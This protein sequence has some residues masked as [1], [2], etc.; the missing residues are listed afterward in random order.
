MVHLFSAIYL[1][2]HS[3]LHK[4]QDFIVRGGKKVPLYRYD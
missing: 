4:L 2:A 3:E 1:W